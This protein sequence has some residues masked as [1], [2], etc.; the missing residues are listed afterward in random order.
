MAL[1]PV[2][3]ITDA[4]YRRLV[5]RCGKPDVIF[6]EFV[7]VDGLCS[8]GRKNLLQHLRFDESEH[9]IVAQFFGTDP[10]K[11]RECARLA[12]ELGFDG[13][14]I[15]MGCPVKVICKQGA[16]AAL[17]NEPELTQEIVQA[18]IEGAGDLPVSVKT[19]IGFSTIDA[20]QWASTLLEANPAA[21][22]F[23]L[24]TRKQ[25]YRP[26]AHWE[27]MPGLVELARGTGVLIIGNGDIQTLQQAEKVAAE[28]GVDGV[29]MG[30]AALGNPWLFR[31]TRQPETITLTE[32]LDTLLEHAALFEA[33]FGFERSFVVMRKHLMAYASGF[34]GAKEL[35]VMLQDVRCRRDVE[36]AVAAF[37]SEKPQ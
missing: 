10:E 11:F 7:S 4:V 32:R 26:S 13:V 3:D 12:V 30:R 29:M 20:E 17:I 37:R 5:A 24:R 34:S 18:T 19:R 25:M 33:V 9:P 36:L 23:H 15:N 16:G 35:R 6:T 28:T 1:A 27:V 31:R 21:I 22:I 14:D 2:A 8:P